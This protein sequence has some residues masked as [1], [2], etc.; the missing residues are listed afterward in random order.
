MTTRTIRRHPTPE[1]RRVDGSRTLLG[2]ALSASIPIQEAH[3]PTLRGPMPIDY[4]LPGATRD[5]LRGRFNQQTK[6]AA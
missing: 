2:G 6:D 5:Q 1:R 3:S 4:A